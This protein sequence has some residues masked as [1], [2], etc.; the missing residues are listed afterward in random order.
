M[1]NRL[2]L[3]PLLACCLPACKTTLPA[4]HFDPAKTPTPPDYRQWDN[5]AALPQRTD[6]ADRTPTPAYLNVQ[7]T[8]SVDVF[9]LHPTTYTGDRRTQTHWNAS[10]ADANI[11]KKTDASSILYQSSVFNGAGR[12]FAPRYRQAHLHAF[13]TKDRTADAEKAIELAYTD[14]LAAFNDYLK[15]ENQGRPFIIAGHSQ[16]ARHAMHLIR[17]VIENTPLQ[18]Q[19]VAAY[20]V[21][22]PV[23]RGFFKNIPP[24]ETPTQT[25]CFCSWRTFNR[26]KILEKYADAPE[27]NT[28]CT[29]PLTWST[30]P[31]IY[32]PKSLNLGGVVRPFHIIYPQMTDAEVYKGVVLSQKPKFRGS[33]FFRT[34]NYHPGDINLFYL[35]VR[36]NA[37]QRTLAFPRP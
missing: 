34:Y 29:N 20:L 26:T 32:A 21:G 37:R 13:Y 1:T 14:V 4:G 22:W 12:V 18:K 35:N 19:L 2:L 7:D 30:Q 5:W 31:G 33:F 16:G 17:E 10:T 27:G 24:C 6:P 3:L 9:F 15:N 8:A 23:E 28:L 11:N 25:G 36:Q